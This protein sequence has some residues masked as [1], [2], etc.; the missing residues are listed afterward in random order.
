M[1]DLITFVP[2]STFIP[3][4]TLNLPQISELALAKGYHGVAGHYSLLKN[5]MLARH[6]KKDQKVGTG[7][8]GSKNCLFREINRNVEWIFSNNAGELQSI[9]NKLT[10]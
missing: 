6:H 8:P 5:K 10:A 4:A 7:Y 2:A 9:I 3:I 1:F